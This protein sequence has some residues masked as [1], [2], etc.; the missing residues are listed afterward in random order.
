MGEANFKAPRVYAQKTSVCRHTK[1]WMYSERKG[2][3]PTNFNGG[4][5]LYSVH[6][7]ADQ[8]IPATEAEDR[9]FQGIFN[10]NQELV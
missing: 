10:L 7:S 5:D 9:R 1:V 6:I 3:W 4:F 8:P 2:A